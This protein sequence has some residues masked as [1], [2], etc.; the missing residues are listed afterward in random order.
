MWQWHR[1]VDGQALCPGA[2]AIVLLN[3]PIT[4]APLFQRLWNEAAIRVA[5]DGGANQLRTQSSCAGPTVCAG[6]WA[7]CTAAAPGSVPE[8]DVPIEHIASQCS[9]D[10]QKSIQAV[11]H[12][13]PETLPLVIYG[14]I[15][16]R[17]DHSM[18]TLHVLSQL[19]LPTHDVYADA[20]L[21]LRPQ[22]LLGPGVGMPGLVT[23]GTHLLRHDRRIHGKSCGLLPL[24]V[25]AAHI[26]TEGLEWN[27]QGEACSLGG[28][29]STSNHL[30]HPDGDVHLTTDAPIY[31]T[32]ELQS[33]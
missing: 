12:L 33:R 4:Q 25:A 22:V 3:T 14:G 24:G 16:S 20:P 7:S 11:E 17:L 21:R 19:A 26:H 8:H 28:F 5:A 23:P 31:W 9:T 32:I 6:D 15:G 29:L 30:V 10:L 1:F 27:L 13:E 18:H 2:Y